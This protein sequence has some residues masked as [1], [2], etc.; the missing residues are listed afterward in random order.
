MCC[1]DVLNISAK[2]SKIG[3]KMEDEDVAICFLRILPKSYERIV[4]NWR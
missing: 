4:L 3:A 1:S 2:L